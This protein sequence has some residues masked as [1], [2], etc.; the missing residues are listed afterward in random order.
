ME[1]GQL[2]R[3]KKDLFHPIV[4]YLRNYPYLVLVKYIGDLPDIKRTFSTYDNRHKMFSENITNGIGVI[5]KIVDEEN[6]E[7]GVYHKWRFSINGDLHPM[8]TGP[9]IVPKKYLYTLIE[10]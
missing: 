3:F 9:L 2:V 5:K 1:V 4:G 7:I 10:K 6:V 8:Y